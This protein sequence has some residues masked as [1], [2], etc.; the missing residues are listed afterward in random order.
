[1]Y[2]AKTTNNRSKIKIA[3]VTTLEINGKTRTILP[4]FFTAE[5]VKL[6]TL[7]TLL[8]AF[9]SE[10]MPQNVLKCFMNDEHAMR[11]DPGVRKAIYLVTCYK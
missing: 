4:Y 3:K 7:W 1:M 2:L 5:H 9:N 10:V 6:Y 8:P 11:H